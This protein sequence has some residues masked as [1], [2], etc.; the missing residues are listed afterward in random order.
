MINDKS[1]FEIRLIGTTSLNIKRHSSFYKSLQNIKTLDWSKLKPF[2]DDK[3]NDHFSLGKSKRRRW[4]K[5]V[6]SIF[7]FSHDVFRRLLPR[8]RYLKPVIV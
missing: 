1:A 8:G 2:A 4:K 6:A 5:M 7:S 3:L